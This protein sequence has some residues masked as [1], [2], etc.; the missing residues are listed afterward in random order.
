MKYNFEDFVKC[1]FERDGIESLAQTFNE[2]DS[3]ADAL[4]TKEDIGFYFRNYIL[5]LYSNNV[6][7][8]D[9]LVRNCDN[10]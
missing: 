9:S 10:V 3:N 6:M 8:Q 5:M 7:E 4:S 1:I 2:I